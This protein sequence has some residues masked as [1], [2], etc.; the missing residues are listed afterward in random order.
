MNSLAWA[1]PP[2]SDHDA[3]EQLC[4]N[5][6]PSDFYFSVKEDMSFTNGFTFIAIVPKLYFVSEKCMWDQ[7]MFLEH[8]LPEDCSEAMESVWDCERSADEVRKDMLARG[9]EENEEFSK[10]VDEDYD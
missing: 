2:Y 6:K 9:F 4:E 10:L 3:Y 7:S 5:S 1:D 8:I